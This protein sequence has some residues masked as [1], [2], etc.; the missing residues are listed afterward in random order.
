MKLL[1]LKERTIPFGIVF[2]GV[3]VGTDN[4]NVFFINIIICQRS[5]G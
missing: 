2:K 5:R 4:L 1:N 3:T